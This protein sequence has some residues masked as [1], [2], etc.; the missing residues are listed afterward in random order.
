MRVL[1]LDPSGNFK[2]G[3]GI[4]GWALFEDGKLRS[5][6]RV[7]SN[8]YGRQES[9]WYGVHF[10]IKQYKPDVVVCESY[11][12]FG[13]KAN[14]QIGSAMETPQLIGYL[15]MVCWAHGIEFVFQDPQNKIRFNDEILVKMG[16]LE[17]KGNR[18]YCMGKPTVDHER[19]AI[20]HGLYYF[21]YRKG[22]QNA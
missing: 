17:K 15:R 20:R 21:R 18:Y 14:Q 5:F 9:Y 13:H 2:E 16:I 19:D 7:D 3:E 12:L 11:R 22:K 6:G 4:T 1:C 8:E 10:L